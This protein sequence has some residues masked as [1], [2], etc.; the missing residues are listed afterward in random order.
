[1]RDLGLHLGKKL[2]TQYSAVLVLVH[3]RLHEG[4]QMMVRDYDVLKWW[5]FET[6]EWHDAQGNPPKRRSAR[7]FATK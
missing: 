2:P 4:L 7:L 5:D 6:F 3:E 1:V